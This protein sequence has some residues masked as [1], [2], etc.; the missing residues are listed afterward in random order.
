MNEATETLAE[1]A[2]A[3]PAA[4]RV[5]YA[6]RLDFCCGGRRPF[7]DACRERGLDADAILD[8][9][10][11]EEAAAPPAPRWELAPLPALVD[12]IVSHYHRR[13]RDSLPTLVQ[14][15]RKVE[16]RHHEKVSCPRGLA[17]LLDHVHRSV[18]D[19]LEKEETI[20]FPALVRRPGARVSGP[21]SVM[22]LEH[23]HHKSDLQR[24]RALTADL[25]PPAEACTT[26][27][28]LYAGLQQFEQ[29]LMEHIHLE[30]NILFRRA[31]AA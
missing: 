4:A 18:L 3:H 11:R 5:F 8:E 7:A 24:I 20:L 16:A 26:W 17:T 25:T 14:M 29:E 1:L 31:L 13:L 28:A 21:V 10:R 23:E 9:I 2:V 15:A 30:N 22:E 19:H 6:N 27:R 12:H